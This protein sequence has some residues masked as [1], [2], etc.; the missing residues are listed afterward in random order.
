MGNCE[1]C[2][3]VGMNV[4]SHLFA[5][6]DDSLCCSFLQW[7]KIHTKEPVE[8][9]LD[10]A[11]NEFSKQLTFLRKHSFLAKTQ[12]HQKKNLMEKLGD[13]EV[14]LHVDFS[15]NFTIKQQNEIMSAHWDQRGITVFTAV[16]TTHNGSQSYAVVSDELCHD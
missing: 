7:T 13:A 6:I 14:I 12:L 8:M 3:D 2:A 10:E 15:E 16:L 9:S 11:K 4:T 1:I 5:D